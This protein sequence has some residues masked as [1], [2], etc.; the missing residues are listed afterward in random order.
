MLK[1]NSK[2]KVYICQQFP[3]IETAIKTNN[4]GEVFEVKNQAG[5]IGIEWAGKFE[6]LEHFASR[7]IF[8][9]VETGKQYHHCNIAGNIEEI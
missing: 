1:E 6:P 9:D 2:I 7:V 4:S 3:N 8:E 5:K